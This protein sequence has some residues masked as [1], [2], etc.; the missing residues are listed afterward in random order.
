MNEK[1]KEEKLDLKALKK[2]K[3]IFLLREAAKKI[4]SDL[5]NQSPFFSEALNAEIF[6]TK[7]YLQHIL[8][9]KKRESS[10]TE[11][12]LII[13]AFL[14]IA[15]QKGIILTT[16]KNLDETF[17]ELGF[18]IKNET[19]AIIILKN[20]DIFTLISSFVKEKNTLSDGSIHYHKP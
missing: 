17:Y 16:R 13:T 3:K 10:E 6:V 7:K 12:R 5:R 1:M 20:K 19:I 14:D 18:S 8:Y 15:I 2:K 9:V 4:V 11:E